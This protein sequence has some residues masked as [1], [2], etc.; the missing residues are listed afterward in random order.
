MADNPK[1]KVQ[2]PKLVLASSSPRRAEILTS[3][4]IPFVVDP[5][6]IEETPRP[7][8]APG[9]TAARLAA[10]KAAVVAALR[11]GA[12]VLA[13]DTLVVL[14]DAVLGK[15]V[16]DAGAARMLRRLAGRDHRVVTGVCLRSDAGP[17]TTLI[18]WSRVRFAAL[19][20]EELAWYVA[21]GEP[22]DK[23]GAYAVQGL[24]ARFIESIEGSFT[25]V[26]GLPA[27]AV[28]R[29]LRETPSLAPLALSCS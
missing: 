29:L 11:P 14:D 15:P 28:Y 1:S 10:A 3:L 26:M 17:G 8:E 6:D 22:R 27:R 4:G 20:E 24:G 19:S 23:A 9:E 25:N 5:A 18:E 21:T 12:W 7:G 2:S 13:A 16:N